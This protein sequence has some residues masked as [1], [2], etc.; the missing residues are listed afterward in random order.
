MMFI[1]ANHRRLSDAV[2]DRIR[3]LI[4]DNKL[5]PGDRLPTEH[6]LAELF[7]VSRTSIREATKALGFFGILNAKPGRGLSV[8]HVDMEQIAS[9]LDI[10]LATS[11]Y[12]KLELIESRIVVESGVLPYVMSRMNEAPEV[13]EVL[14]SLNNQLRNTHLTEDRIA[15]D[16]RFHRS[17][18]LAS[19]LGPLIVFNDLLQIFF[20]HFR[21]S[22]KRGDWEQAVVSHQII[23]D[24]LRDGRLEIAN[25]EVHRHIACHKRPTNA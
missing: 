12:P 14:Q 24:S 20:D 7:G 8:G 2:T 5:R 16:C 15:I 25:N 6:S 23:I 18:I 1:Q 9:C 21:K 4:I 11:D 10:Q 22:L 3:Y 13:Y 17:L 19:N